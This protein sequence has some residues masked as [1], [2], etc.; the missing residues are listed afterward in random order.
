MELKKGTLLQGG[1]YKIEKKLGQG[2][3]GITYLA[4][5]KFSTKGSLGKMDVLAK[6][7]IKEFFMSDINSRK[8][9][10]S[11]VDG[12]TGSI[13]TNYKKKFRKEAEN[14]AKLLHPNIVKVF[15]VFDENSTTYYVM[16]YLSD[17]NLNKYIKDKNSLSEKECIALTEGIGEA[18]QYMHDTLMLH[19]DL[20][21]GNIMLHNNEAVLIDFGLS[22]QFNANGQPETSTTIGQG[23][24]GY[25]PLEQQNYN[26][27][28]TKG[29]PFA[30]DVYA[31][32]GTMF[33]MVTGQTPPD[34]S[35]IFNDG[36]PKKEL[37]IHNISSRLADIIEKAM[38]PSKKE[39]YQSVSELLLAINPTK[40]ISKKQSIS[41]EGLSVNDTNTSEDLTR[42]EQCD[43][44]EAIIL[45]GSQAALK[46]GSI[47]SS[48]NGN[49]YVVDSVF[50]GGFNFTYICHNS[51]DHN[52]KVVVR[53]LFFREY[54]CR[55]NGIVSSIGDID[56]INRYHQRFTEIGRILKTLSGHPNIENFVDS[57]K[58]N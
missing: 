22:K 7:A 58:A 28:Q 9:D 10:G 26:G 18:L 50:V 1:K 39:R 41:K 12:S 14:L 46:L 49:D 47:I 48:P 54:N 3:F 40:K 27:S 16:E 6:V 4:T 31:L 30:M 53:E 8:E 25:A 23:T 29:L 34:A 51:K 35:S 17:T 11:T 19:L 33:K 37:A 55:K 21:P 2:S 24:P 56:W 38:A 36:F 15:D 42:L 43:S 32:G 57:F 13:F 45:T 5:A 44:S 20:K 52:K